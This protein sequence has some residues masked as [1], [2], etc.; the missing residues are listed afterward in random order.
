MSNHSL[1]IVLVSYNGSFWLKKTLLSLEKYYLQ[2]TD[3]R[4]KVWLVD[5]AS[6][7]DCV[8]MTQK[9]FPFVTIIRSPTN[10]GFAAGNNLALRK[11]NS[12]YVF[13]LNTDTE[14]GEQ[15]NLDLLMDYLDANP[16]VGMIGPKLL[17]TGGQLDAACHRGEPTPWASFCYFFGLAKLFPRWKLFAA[18]HRSDLDLN[19]VHPI[20]A[21]SGATMM[22][23]KTAMDKVGLLD[24][25][26]FLYAEDLDWAHQ[27]RLK[28]YQ[29]IYYPEV[30]IT[31]HKNKSGIANQDAKIKGKS[32]A[33]FY[34]TMLQ[35]YDKYY[36]KSHPRWCRQLLRLFL[37]IK[38]C[39]LTN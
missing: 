35:Y 5:N 30:V 19:T 38:R 11:V 20:E 1:D 9:E 13:L 31:H 37:F 3:S 6:S 17:L 25:S 8:A 24:E 4:V 7:D 16:Q 2:Q 39:G 23:R 15:S 21:I 28:G 18:Y 12:D 29:I 10:V 33:Y 32:K 34:D 27:F 26:F 14:L 22:V 36:A